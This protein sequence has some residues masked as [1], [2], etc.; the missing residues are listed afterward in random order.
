[1]NRKKEFKQPK[2]Q[3]ATIR[4]SRFGLRRTYLSPQ[5]RPSIATYSTPGKG[6]NGEHQN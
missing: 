6:P 1:M 4:D 5:E 3:L 2:A